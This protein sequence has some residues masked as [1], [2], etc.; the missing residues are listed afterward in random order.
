MR[1]HDE[2]KEFTLDTILKYSY[3][4]SEEATI[5]YELV[6]K[7]KKET[8]LN[9]EEASLLEKI[10]SNQLKDDMIASLKKDGSSLILEADVQSNYPDAWSHYCQKVL[11]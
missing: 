10:L 4:S 8:K 11:R 7:I 3:E 9:R 5:M 6:M 1:D 2:I